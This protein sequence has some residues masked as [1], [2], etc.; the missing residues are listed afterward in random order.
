MIFGDTANNVP[1][2]CQVPPGTMLFFLIVAN[3]CST[4]EPPPWYGEN[5]A[6]LRLCAQSLVPENLQASIDGV[7]VQNLD[8]YVFTSPL[9]KFTMPEDNIF[10]VPA[11]STGESVSYG[12]WLML[13]PLDPGMHTIY[14]YGSLPSV[15]FESFQTYEL[16]VTR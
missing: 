15:P 11:G 14:L 12:A 13:A 5:E 4:L 3:E 16:T 7:E 6:E 1:L 8:Q 10:G 2:K 9:Y